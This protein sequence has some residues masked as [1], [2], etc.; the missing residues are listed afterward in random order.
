M[1][2]LSRLSVGT[3]TPPASLSP[4]PIV[5]SSPCVATQT[6]PTDIEVAMHRF[7]GGAWNSNTLVQNDTVVTV[8]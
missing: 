7:V 8:G 6:T 5:S 1:D 4:S 3:Q 2:H